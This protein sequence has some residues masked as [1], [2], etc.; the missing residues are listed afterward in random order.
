MGYGGLICSDGDADRG[1]VADRAIV[2]FDRVGKAIDAKKAGVGRIQ[3]GTIAVIDQVP[4]SWKRDFRGGSRDDCAVAV[5]VRAVAVV[6]QDVNQNCGIGIRVYRV[7]AYHWW[8]IFCYANNCFINSTVCRIVFNPISDI[9]SA[10]HRIV[11]D[12]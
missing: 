7:V 8:L 10:C 4:A 2:I 1:C 11:I 9:N 12:I 6:S 3:K 5:T